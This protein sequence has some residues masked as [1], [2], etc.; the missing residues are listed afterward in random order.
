MHRR[1]VALATAAYWVAL[2]GALWMEERG[3]TGLPGTPSG[4]GELPPAVV[5]STPAALA[6]RP[7]A[8]PDAAH[9]V[10]VVLSTQRRDQ[11]SVYGGPV[12]LPFLDARAAEGAVMMDAVAVA[13]SST[14]TLASIFAGRYPHGL[15]VVDVATRDAPPKLRSDV[16]TLAEHFA[17]AGWTTLASSA[18][19]ELGLER[20]ANQGFEAFTDRSFGAGDASDTVAEA[21]ALVERRTDPTVPMF[22]MVVLNDSRKP[23]P[24]AVEGVSDPGRPW[25]G[26]YRASLIRQDAAVASLV[27]GLAD[28]G[29]DADDTLF[30]VLADHGEGLMM[31]ARHR[32]RHGIVLYESSVSIPWLW[33]GK[34][35]APGAEVQGLASQVD[36]APTLAALA[37]AGPFPGDGVDLSESVRSGR[38]SPRAEA[39]AD[40]L[41]DGFDRASVWTPTHQCQRDYGSVNRPKDDDFVAGCFDRVADPEF[42]WPLSSSEA[43]T[44]LLRRLDELHDSRLGEIPEARP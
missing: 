41:V 17:G 21:L 33:W 14:P 43:T 5:A 19:P 36:L 32:M 8:P 24:V 44:S 15:G 30:A 3:R 20:G 25:V 40:T 22:L 34:G 6:P 2:G 42:A 29:I 35:V 38:P 39:Y 12:T 23:A 13:V 16:V 4:P 26:R 11:W 37:G 1:M 28:R 10:L 18:A 31:P 7:D 9:V 27:Q